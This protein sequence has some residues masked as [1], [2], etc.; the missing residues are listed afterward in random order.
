M[1]LLIQ[2]TNTMI[3]KNNPTR[4]IKINRK[5][6]KHNPWVTKGA[7]ISINKKKDKLYKLYI[8]HNN[9]DQE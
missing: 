2:E 8:N 1:Q 7:S 9:T 3:D 4:A 6:I 5:H